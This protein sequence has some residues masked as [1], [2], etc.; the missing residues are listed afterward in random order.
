MRVVGE[1]PCI[2]GLP[3]WS[4]GVPGLRQLSTKNRLDDT[5]YRNN[6]GALANLSALR[7]VIATRELPTRTYRRNACTA[8]N[9]Q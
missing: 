3:R 8:C 1:P 9:P 5:M 4:G 7:G 2:A 6:R